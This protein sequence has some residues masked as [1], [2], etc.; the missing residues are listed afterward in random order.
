MTSTICIDII[1]YI[2][3]INHSVAILKRV[4]VFI[5][6]LQPFRILFAALNIDNTVNGNYYY[7][8]WCNSV[9]HGKGIYV[10]K[11]K[12]Q[13]MEGVWVNGLLKVN[14]IQYLKIPTAIKQPMMPE[15]S[16][17]QKRYAKTKHIL[18]AH[19]I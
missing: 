5:S 16:I 4:N 15:V 14:V 17:F 3:I 1:Y 12:N 6:F 7:G 8:Q 13:F 19:F 9:K 18:L 10:F 2:Y 11:D